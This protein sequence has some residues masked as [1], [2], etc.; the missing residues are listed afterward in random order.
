[1]AQE[2]RLVY[3]VALA[4]GTSTTPAGCRCERALDGENQL[5]LP[6]QLGLEDAHVG[7]V[8]WD[9]DKRVLGHQVPSL[10]ASANPAPIL[11]RLAPAR[12]PYI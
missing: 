7:N 5:A 9:R 11:H 10:R 3:T 1:M 12:N 8:E 2:A 4:D 6:G